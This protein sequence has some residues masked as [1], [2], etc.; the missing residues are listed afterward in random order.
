MAAAIGLARAGVACEIAEA[1]T[2]WRP[3]GVGIGLQSPSLRATKALGLFDAIRRVGRPHPHIVIGAADG[4][5][6]AELPQAH[7]NDPRDPP[8]LTMSRIALHQVMADEVLRGAREADLTDDGG[9]LVPEQDT[10]AVVTGANRGIGLEVVRR[11]AARGWT[12]V[13]G[14]RDVE[15]GRRAARGLDGV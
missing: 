8:L 2:Q 14:S 4:T 11:L 13:L 12:V 9:G 6:V 3:A 10:V 1:T 5:R 15:R 7:V